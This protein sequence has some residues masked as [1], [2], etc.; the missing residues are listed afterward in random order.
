MTDCNLEEIIKR[1]LND[2]GF[3]LY[4]VANNELNCLKAIEE[5]ELYGDLLSKLLKLCDNDYLLATTSLDVILHETHI[6]KNIVHTNLSFDEPV[7]FAQKICV[8]SDKYTR[9]VHAYVEIR[10]F[11]INYKQKLQKMKQKKSR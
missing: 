4:L 3:I 6:S 5:Y 1:C 8:S 2:E 10:N 9:V 11:Y 7:P